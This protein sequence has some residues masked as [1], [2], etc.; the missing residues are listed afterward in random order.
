M[1]RKQNSLQL[2][3][4]AHTLGIQ[5]SNLH[6]YEK[7]ERSPTLEVILTYHILFGA[8]LKQL[9]HQQYCELTNTV[10]QRCQNL[11]NSLQKEVEKSP[12]IKRRISQ[13]DNIVNSLNP[14]KSAYGF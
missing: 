11:L 2:S 10:K 1:Y 4:V 12:K 8:N 9:F 6:R 13:L 3:D 5:P 14:V 7:G